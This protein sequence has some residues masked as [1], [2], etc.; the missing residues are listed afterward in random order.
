MQRKI[1]EKILWIDSQ[2]ME[3]GGTTNNF[4]YNI[5]NILNVDNYKKLS[6]QLIDCI[7]SKNFNLLTLVTYPNP[8]FSTI[9]KIYINLNV[10]G[11]SLSNNNNGLLLGLINNQSTT[12]RLGSGGGLST[13]DYS[14]NGSEK[15]EENKIK[16]YLNDIPTGIINISIIGYN[17]TGTGGTY[18]ENYLVDITTPTAQRPSNEF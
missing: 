6:V 3:S 16:Y 5:G 13:Y 17:N 12:L 1:E 4:Y 7:I 10:Y 9:I 15:L 18:V 11:N 14:N 8:F 2:Y